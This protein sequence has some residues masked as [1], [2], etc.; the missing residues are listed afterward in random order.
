VLTV[1]SKSVWVDVFH[2]PAAIFPYT[3]PALFSMFAGFA[4]VWL[5][6][7][8]DKSPRAAIDKAGFEAQE[9]RSETGYR[10]LGGIGALSTSSNQTKVVPA[11]AGTQVCRRSSDAGST[12]VPAFAGTTVFEPTKRARILFLHMGM[13]FKMKHC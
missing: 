12:W 1:L 10:R 7:I 4:G 6:S 11:K 13:R 5:F 2:N 8:T 3:S 9:V